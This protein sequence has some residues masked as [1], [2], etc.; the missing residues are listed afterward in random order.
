MGVYPTKSGKGWGGK[1]KEFY[2]ELGIF[3]KI[4][5]LGD[6]LPILGVFVENF[7]SRGGNLV[8]SESIGKIKGFLARIYI[9]EVKTK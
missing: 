7:A 4:A 3:G 2:E 1:S 6:I 5:F 8:P 9:H